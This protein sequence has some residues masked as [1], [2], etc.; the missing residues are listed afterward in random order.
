[1]SRAVACHKLTVAAITAV[2]VGLLFSLPLAGQTYRTFR[3]EL[4]RI[5]EQARWRLGRIWIDPSLSFSFQYD[6][7]IYGASEQNEPV[8]DYVATTSIPLT[9]Y[10]ISGDWLMFSFLASPQYV[11]FFEISSE[12]ALNA[13]YSPGLRM[14]L[15]NNFVLSGEYQFSRTKERWLAEVETRVTREIQGWSSSLF[16]ETSRSTSIGL[17]FS[18]LDI[19]YEDASVGDTESDILRGL[20]RNEKISRLEFYY[21]IFSDSSFFTVL[22]YSDYAFKDPESKNKDSYSY[23]FDLGVRFP[24]L[25]RARGILSLGYKKF[26]PKQEGWRQFSGIVGNTNLELRVRSFNFRLLF[27]IDTPFSYSTNNVFYLEY[28]FG[29]GISYHLT[30][31]IRLDYDFTYGENDYPEI[32]LALAPDGSIQAIKKKDTYRTHAGSIVI[33]VV[34][35]T[36]IGLRVSFYDRTTNYYAMNM[37]RVIYGAFVTYEF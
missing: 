14:L 26:V 1:M 12:R 30:S 29:T 22:D 18:D 17:S 16:Y 27:Q 10:L 31:S 8:S 4:E 13:S 25:G 3:S 36:G 15:F 5:T 9:F 19:S 34:R 2:L 21:R 11:H 7:N 20:N 37:S 6:S 32:D 33:R 24:R 23:Q 28:R 35:N